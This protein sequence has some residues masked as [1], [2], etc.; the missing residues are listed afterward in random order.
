MNPQEQSHPPDEPI[1]K[2]TIAAS[3]FKHSGARNDTWYVTCP[4]WN[5]KNE[6]N[7]AINMHINRIVD[8]IKNHNEHFN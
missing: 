5:Y 8:E 3:L 4:E 6:T 2:F 7:E 1:E